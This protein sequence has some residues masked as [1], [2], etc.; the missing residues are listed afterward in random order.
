MAR[1]I[2]S[3][4]LVVVV[5]HVSIHFNELQEYLPISCCRPLGR[6]SLI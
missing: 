2:T 4:L 6:Y 5:F 1:V 3:G